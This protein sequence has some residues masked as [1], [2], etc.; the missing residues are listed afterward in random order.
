MTER[1]I[2]VLECLK[3][4]REQNGNPCAITT[5]DHNI[6]ECVIEHIAKAVEAFF[7]IKANK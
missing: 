7:D 2:T 5:W 3:V 6:A 1:E 4:I